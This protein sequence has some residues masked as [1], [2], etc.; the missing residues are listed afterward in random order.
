[1]IDIDELI[2]QCT[3]AVNDAD[4]LLATREVLRRTVGAGTDHTLDSSRGAGLNVLHCT[5]DL[6]ILDVVWPP[7]VSILPHDHR[8]WAAIG[9]YQG[10]EDNLLY[11]REGSTIVETRTRELERHDVLLLGDDTIHGVHNPKRSYTGAIHVY[12]GDLVSVSRSQWDPATLLEEPY[13][14]AGVQ[15]SFLEAAERA[16]ET[17]A[18]G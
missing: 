12:G 14:G 13:D 9:I 15:R 6:T 2:V 1:V 5:P 3:A 7:F 17:Q 16:E 10:R 11:R 8:M 18:A 4:P